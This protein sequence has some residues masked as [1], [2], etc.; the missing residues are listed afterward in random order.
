[1]PSQNK[2]KEKDRPGRRYPRRTIAVL[3]G[4]LSFFA[5]L[6]LALRVGGFA[7]SRLHR[8]AISPLSIQSGVP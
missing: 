8:K 3:L 1:M 6:E 5:L 7:F 4:F 2:N